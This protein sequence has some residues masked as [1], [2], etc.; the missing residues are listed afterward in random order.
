MN[1]GLKIGLIIGGSLIVLGGGVYFGLPIYWKSNIQKK[2][3]ENESEQN[4]QKFKEALNKMSF[5]ELKLVNE[6]S[7]NFANG[8]S[9]M[10]FSSEKLEKLRRIST[11]YNIFT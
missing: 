2:F 8:I 11:K 7:N 4:K 10:S 9:K 6:Y 1:K 5:S 3:T